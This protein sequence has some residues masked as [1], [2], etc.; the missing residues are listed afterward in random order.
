MVLRNELWSR[1]RN[2]T[3]DPSCGPMTA[4]ILGTGSFAPERVV[5]NFSLVASRQ[6]ETTPD[7][8]ASK[9][10][11][12]ERRFADD[13][14]KASDLATEAA[15]R[16]LEAAKIS[17][18]DVDLFIVATS[19]P[20]YT[21]PATAC[22]VQG[23]LG[24]EGGMAFDVSNACAGFVTAMDIAARMLQ[25]NTETA[26]VIG[27]DIGS[28]LVDPQDRTTSVFFGDGAGAVVLSS[29]G[30]GRVL[31][32]RV[33][34]RGDSE[35]LNV[36]VGGTMTMNGKAIWDFATRVLPETVRYL[37]E[38]A[39]V[40]VDEIKLLVPHQANENII[41]CGATEVGISMDRVALNIDRYGNTIGASIPI[42]LDEALRQ[43]RAR[44]GDHVMLVGFGAGLSWGGNLLQL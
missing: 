32:S 43:G 4:T 8:I 26:V 15:L 7:W 13:G 14:V 19:T 36:P 39:R 17:P 28:R 5:D 31:A 24:A 30:S 33:Q 25:T 40:P 6:L 35:S 10:G 42:A 18:D 27:V 16:A 1:V 29:E 11:I 22:L 3:R 12:L 20:D 38:K 2:A 23:N 37:C 21:M 34:S 9:T 41:R 44:P